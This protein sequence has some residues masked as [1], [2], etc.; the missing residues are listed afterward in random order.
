MSRVNVHTDLRA[1]FADVGNQGRRPTCLAFAT[2]SAHEALY[3]CADPLC[4]EWLYY[5]AVMHAGDP[6]TAGSS[7][8]STRHVLIN[9]GQPDESFWPYLRSGVDVNN[10]QPPTTPPTKLFHAKAL[11]VSSAYSEISTSLGQGDASI[12]GLN[13]GAAFH[14]IDRSI[15]DAVVPDETEHPS[16][17][18]GHALLAVGSGELGNSNYLL[19]RNSWGPRWGDDGCAWISESHVRDR[20]MGGFRL[21]EI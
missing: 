19:I 2:T 14:S 11:D 15:G 10:W 1:G 16:Q 4:I 12:I 8:Q 21:Q 17:G 13:I 6:P 20:W 9:N 5:H 7:L 3:K 18:A